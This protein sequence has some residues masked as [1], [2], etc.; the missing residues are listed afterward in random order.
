VFDLG[1]AG[2]ETLRGIF[3]PSYDTQIV[4][5]YLHTQFRESAS[6]YAEKYAGVE[7]FTGLLSQ[8][9]ESI[10]WQGQDRA[11]RT[12]LDIGSGAG[13]SIFPLLQLC[14]DPLLIASDLS[15]D[16]L[17]LLKKALQEQHLE[18]SCVLLQLNAEELDFTPDSFDLV[19]GAAVLHHLFAPDKTLEGCARILKRGGYALFFEPF[20]AGHAILQLIYR[21][22]VQ[23]ARQ[24]T[25]AAEVKAFLQAL[26]WEYEV[27]AKRDKSLPVFRHIDDK[28]L[29]T[30]RYIEDLADQQGFST[31]TIYSLYTPERQFERQTEVNLRLGIGKGRDSLPRWA[32]DIVQQ[33]DETFSDDLKG[34]L[35]LEGGVILK[36]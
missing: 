30:K 20:E 7:L 5:H 15:V 24:A 22:I 32:W 1:A 2:N 27:R 11:G 19:V 8:A 3:S 12:I 26:S 33:Y 4:D 13:N 29:F 9:F 35:L 16:L 31:C 28:W 14:P 6:V 21:A 36:K 25:L 10:Q 18:H 23:D 34:D 17:V